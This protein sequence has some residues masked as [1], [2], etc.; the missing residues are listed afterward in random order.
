MIPWPEMLDALALKRLVQNPTTYL[1]GKGF[2]AVVDIKTMKISFLL[3]ET[4]NGLIWG[5][6]QQEVVPGWSEIV[7]NIRHNRFLD[8]PVAFLLMI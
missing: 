4:L 2:G 7:N 8:N 3:D 6:L 5:P 1:A